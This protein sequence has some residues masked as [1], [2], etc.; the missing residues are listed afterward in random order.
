M[1]SRRSI[2]PDYIICLEDGQKMMMLKRYIG[3]R[4]GLTPQQYREKWGLPSD[5]P[6]VAPAYSERR[7]TLAKQ[8]GLGRVERP[9]DPVEVKRIPAGKR[10]GRRSASKPEAS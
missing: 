9:A 2:F 10:G 5:Y 7:S 8:F 1:P 6:M 3:T 4:Y